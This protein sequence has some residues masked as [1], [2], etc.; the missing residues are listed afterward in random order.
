MVHALGEIRRVLLRDGILIDLRPLLEYAPLEVVTASETR[1]AGTA[2]QLPDDRAGDEAANRAVAQVE[3]QDWF[4]KER[5]DFFPFNYYWDSPTEM[6]QYLEAEWS[7]SVT[8]DEE[9]W[10]NVRSMWAVANADA[11]V[12]IQ[13]KMLITRWRKKA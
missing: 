1:L 6:Q 4:I 11:R 5:E 13:L 3:G 10:R 12:R 8:V 7:N 2:D 9:V